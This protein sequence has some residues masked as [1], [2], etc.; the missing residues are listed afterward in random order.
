MKLGYLSITLPFNI[1]LFAYFGGNCI[2]FL[3]VILVSWWILFQLM[4]LF[5]LFFFVFAI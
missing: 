4:I 3:F 5:I 2:V 1:L